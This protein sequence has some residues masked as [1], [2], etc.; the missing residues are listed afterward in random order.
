MRHGGGES[1]GWLFLAVF[2]PLALASFLFCGENSSLRNWRPPASDDLNLDREGQRRFA[3]FLRSKDTV[4]D[5]SI[6][7][8]VAALVLWITTGVLAAVAFGGPATWRRAS[9]SST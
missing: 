5:P 7:P 3:R 9:S 2:G 4:P 1:Y 8:A 6:A